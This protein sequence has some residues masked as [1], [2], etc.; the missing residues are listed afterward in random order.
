LT[1]DPGAQLLRGDPAVHEV[2]VPKHH[3]RGAEREAVFDALAARC[4][5]LAVSTTRYDGIPTLLQASGA[6]CVTA[7]WRQ[8]PAEEP[9]S[10]R[11]L[12]ILHAEGLL[13]PVDVDRPARIR[14]TPDEL[15]KGR[16]I[17]GHYPARP[18]VLVT[19]A[20]MAVKRWPYWR[21]LA[22]LLRT[23]GHP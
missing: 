10:L 1:H 18:V 6:R 21:R 17:L 7:L 19:E 16:R 9:V 13:D 11:Y 15:T 3:R 8:P 14:L 2:R 4:P 20:G 5:D 22:D 12:R 23:A